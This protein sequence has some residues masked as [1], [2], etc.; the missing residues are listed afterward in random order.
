MGKELQCSVRSGG[1]RSDGKAL[2][3]TNEIVFRGDLRLK[4]PLASIKSVVARNGELHLKWL[5]N[6]TVFELGEQAEK[7]A[8]KILHPKSTAEKLGIK[9]GSRISALRLSETEVLKDARKAAAAF[10]DDKPLRDSDVVFFGADSASDLAGIK[11]VIPALAINGA[12]WIVYPK[13]RKEITELQVLNAGREAGLVDIKV[14][15]YSATHTALKF[16]RPKSKR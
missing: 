3:E 14:V 9:P 11:K 16:V 8:H 1:K 15:G 10:A 13:G 5:E 7:W 4:I 2:L 12:L 6:S